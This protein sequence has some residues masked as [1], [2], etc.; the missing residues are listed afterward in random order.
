MM[1][2]FQQSIHGLKNDNDQLE[3][4]NDTLQFVDEAGGLQNDQ[5]KKLQKKLKQEKDNN[6][7]L[8]KQIKNLQNKLSEMEQQ[9]N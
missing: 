4:S 2:T 5:A 8:T 1:S 6:A 3:L 7:E 9:L